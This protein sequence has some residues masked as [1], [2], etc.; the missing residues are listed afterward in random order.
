[1]SAEPST[2]AARSDRESTHDDGGGAEPPPG[3]STSVRA[4]GRGRRRAAGAGPEGRGRSRG[5]RPGPTRCRSRRCGCRAS[6]AWAASTTIPAPA[7]MLRFTSASSR[8]ASSPPDP[9]SM[10]AA[11]AK[12]VDARSCSAARHAS[13]PTRLPV[14]ASSRPPVSSAVI[15]GFASSVANVTGEFVRIDRSRAAPRALANRMTVDEASKAMRPSAGTRR[16]LRRDASLGSGGDGVAL[17]EGLRTDRPGAAAHPVCDAAPFELGEVSPDRH[18]ADP[19]ALSR[20]G[21]ADRP[22]RREPIAQPAGRRS[23]DAR[24]PCPIVMSRHLDR[25][26][27]SCDSSQN[28]TQERR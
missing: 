4:V 26:V 12:K 17:G 24:L 5:D 7:A 13:G 22:V 23:S 1:M 9:G 25:L 11:D 19:E 2:I 27:S 10:A 6:A 3:G 15:P 28:L 8:V 20:L 16:E 14:R 18:L 21:D